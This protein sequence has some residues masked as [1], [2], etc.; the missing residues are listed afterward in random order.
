MFIGKFQKETIMTYKSMPFCQ[1][2]DV[3][4]GPSA[5]D[6]APSPGVSTLYAAHLLVA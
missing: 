6:V 5:W 4:L 3:L 2:H 1:V